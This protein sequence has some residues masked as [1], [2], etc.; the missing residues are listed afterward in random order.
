MAI[1]WRHLLNKSLG[2]MRTDIAI[3]DQTEEIANDARNCR[4]NRLGE[5]RRCDGFSKI[6]S[7]VED[8]TGEIVSGL[9]AAVTGL[10]QL[11]KASGSEYLIECIDEYI[12][13]ENYTSSNT[14]LK[15]G[16]SPGYFYCF[17]TFLDNAIIVNGQDR[18]L[19]YDGITCTNLSITAPV[20]TTFS[21]QTDATVGSLGSGVYQYFVTFYNSITEEESN[22]Q[23][24]ANIAS[25]DTSTTGATSIGIY[26]IPVST[27]GQVTARKIYRTSVDGSYLR[28][29]YLTTINDNIT[30]YTSVSPLVDSAADSSLGALIEFDHDTAP[31]FEKIVLHKERLWGFTENSS[32]LYYGKISHLGYFPQNQM[33]LSYSESNATAG[34]N[35][36]IPIGDQ[37][38]DKI[39]NIIS[40]YDILL[41]FKEN[42]VYA[43][44]GYDES[45]FYI[46]KIDFS[47]RVGCI[48][49]RG[50]CVKDNYCYF[51]DKNGLYKTNGLAID[52]SFKEPMK[53]FFDFSGSQI[54]K[55]NNAYLQDSICIADNT[56]PNDTVNFYFRT[57][58]SSDFIPYYVN[59]IYNNR[60]QQ[61][62]YDTGYALSSICIYE[63]SNI[64]SLIH[65]DDY[66]IIWEHDNT[67]GYGYGFY[68]NDPTNVASTNTTLTDI[69]STTTVIGQYGEL[70]GC[71]IEITEGTGAGQKRFIESSQHNGVDETEVTIDIPWDTNP[72]NTSKYIIGGIDFF[73][74]HRWC[75]YGDNLITKRQKYIKLRAS[76]NNIYSPTFG[77]YYDYALEPS[78]EIQPEF[79]V[80]SYVYG[81]GIY[82]SA[83]YGGATLIDKYIAT[84]QNKIH[85]NFSISI[86]CKIPGFDVVFYNYDIVYQT[87]GYGIR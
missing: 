58:M 63:N 34:N 48:S 31:E 62:T 85:N 69:M 47:D 74:Q 84:P 66:G 72:D 9:N 81:S 11:R 43:L 14:V 44:Y 12:L 65:G 32:Y 79:V 57:P 71:Y 15:S 4:I 87:K 73:Y 42:N 82:G 33:G 80:S 39:T 46:K 35:Y 70:K 8:N 6:H 36:I 41:I 64:D 24:I 28:A 45:D 30:T 10:Y 13:K 54:Y 17:D 68:Q 29:Q 49:K 52:P 2:G 18:A 40:F 60:T 25:F 7:D 77:L 76:V 16:Q 86:G 75:G 83:V 37:D 21:A 20:T 53:D 27:D 56:R 78:S 19:K 51:I 61:F 22:P 59:I 3:V 23:P 38:G 26:N 67:K 5:V 55:I 1:A 50:A